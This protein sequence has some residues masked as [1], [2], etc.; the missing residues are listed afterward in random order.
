MSCHGGCLRFPIAYTVLVY[1]GCVYVDE[2]A[3]SMCVVY[4]ARGDSRA[5]CYV[6]MPC[7]LRVFVF[8]SCIKFEAKF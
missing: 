7:V 6:V 3:E 2:D 8:T 1:L 5:C 4:A